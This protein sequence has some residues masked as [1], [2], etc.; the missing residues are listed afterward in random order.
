MQFFRSNY[1]IHSYW[2]LNLPLK[3]QFQGKVACPKCM[4]EFNSNPSDFNTHRGFKVAYP[5]VWIYLCSICALILLWFNL[6]TMAVHVCSSFG[7]VGK[8]H[9]SLFQLRFPINM[10][11]STPGST[12]GYWGLIFNDRWK[13]FHPALKV[14]ICLS[15]FTTLWLCETLEKNKQ[16]SR[17]DQK[18]EGADTERLSKQL[19]VVPTCWLLHVHTPSPLARRALLVTTIKASAMAKRNTASLRR[20]I[21]PM[22][23]HVSCDQCCEVS[24]IET[25]FR[26]RQNRRI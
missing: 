5:Y 1:R 11:K 25:V 23:Y 4:K 10:T 12:S 8:F 17:Q 13:R 16:R 26:L 14:W 2:T 15:S 18:T 24:A 22:T 19:A 6:F 20:A 7:I 9:F 21:P 3:L